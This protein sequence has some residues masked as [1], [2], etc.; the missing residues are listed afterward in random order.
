MVSVS[1]KNGKNKYMLTKEIDYALR[2]VM[3]LEELLSEKNEEYFSV[4][5]L[6]EELNVPYRFLRK[7]SG[8]LTF[9]GICESSRGKYG[10]IK[11]N[12]KRGKLTLLEV[13]RAV[14]NDSLKLNFCLRDEDV[15]LRSDKCKL[16]PV[17]LELQKHLEAELGALTFRGIIA[18]N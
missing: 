18:D 7:I 4:T 16:H 9:A 5:K 15:C 17:F 8:K 1:L 13:L 6:S 12:D 10:G 14:D 11:L 3:H 2:L